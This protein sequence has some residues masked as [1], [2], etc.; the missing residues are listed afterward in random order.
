[1]LIIGNVL[2]AIFFFA[3]FHFLALTHYG[4]HFFESEVLK[5]IFILAMPDK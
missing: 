5:Q 3:L 4:S 2:Y 1:M